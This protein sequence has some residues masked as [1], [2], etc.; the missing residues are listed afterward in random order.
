[1]TGWRRVKPDCEDS[2]K[3]AV[4]HQPVV[5][6]LLTDE[7]FLAYKHKKNKNEKKSKDVDK[8]VNITVA[9]AFFIGSIISSFL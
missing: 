3:F 9:F 4:A 8:V 5:V 2:L 6:S 1:M 7:K